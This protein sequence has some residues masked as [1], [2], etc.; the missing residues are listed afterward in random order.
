MPSETD[1]YFPFADSESEARITPGAK[2]VP[3]PS[4]WGHGGG[5]ER[6]PGDAELLDQT[7][8]GFLEGR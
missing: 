2:L 3:I 5:A 6:G 7:I 1:P 8:A 4:N